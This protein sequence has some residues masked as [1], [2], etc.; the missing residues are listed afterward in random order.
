MNRARKRPPVRAGA[1][2]CLAARDR[3]LLTKTA[4][5]RPVFDDVTRYRALCL[6]ADFGVRPE[7]AT[8]LA[9]LAFGGAR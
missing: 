8:M 3:H 1:D 2:L 9:A 5:H 4:T 7:L 6:I